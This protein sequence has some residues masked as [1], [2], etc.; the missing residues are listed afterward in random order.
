MKGILVAIVA[1]IGL[2]IAIL[3]AFGD[4]FTAIDFFNV[5]KPAIEGNITETVEKGSYF[6]SDYIIGAAYWMLGIAI[7]SSVLAIFGIKIK[8]R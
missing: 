6:L 5:A 3:G 7:I 2:V 4:M 8:S 1:A